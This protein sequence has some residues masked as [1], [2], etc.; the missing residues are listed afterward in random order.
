[1][2]RLGGDPEFTNFEL[3]NFGAARDSK[4]RTGGRVTA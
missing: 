3:F 2:L 4:F 1:M